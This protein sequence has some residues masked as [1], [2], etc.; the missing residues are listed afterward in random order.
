VQAGYSSF[1]FLVLLE[2][3]HAHLGVVGSFQASQDISVNELVLKRSDTDDGNRTILRAREPSRYDWLIS[4]LGRI[5]MNTR[6]AS[7]LSIRSMERVRTGVESSCCENHND[8]T[9]IRETTKNMGRVGSLP[10][11]NGACILSVK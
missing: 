11:W 8:M 6:V 3:A 10:T 2:M 9:V 1:Q 4:D 7:E 5:D